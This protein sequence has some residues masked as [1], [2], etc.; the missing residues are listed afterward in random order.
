[1][2]LAPAA[3]SAASAPAALRALCAPGTVRL[4]STGASPGTESQNRDPSGRARKPVMCQS[5]PVSKPNR[6]TGAAPAGSD[7]PSP[8]TTAP[9]SGTWATQSAKSCSTSASDPNRA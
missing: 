9:S 1:M 8:S 3:A 2:G 6:T 7:T 4:T 5:A